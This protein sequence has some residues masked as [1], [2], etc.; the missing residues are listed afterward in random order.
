MLEDNAKRYWAQGSVGDHCYGGLSLCNGLLEF[1]RSV[2]MASKWIMAELI[3]IFHGVDTETASKAVDAVVD[4]TL[5]IVWEVA[6]R[7]R[8]LRSDLSMLDSTLVLLYGTR[9][10]VSEAELF[11]WVGHSNASVYRRDVLMAAH[12]RR[13][14][15]YDRANRTVE[16]S[17]LGARYVEHHVPLEVAA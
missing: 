14:L 15:E 1:T 6:G 2:L 11:E 12:K 7:K 10:V 4:R 5:P 3:R 9:G 8:V 17:P 16:I 13:L